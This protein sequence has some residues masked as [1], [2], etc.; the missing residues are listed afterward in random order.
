MKNFTL[1]I[2]IAATILLSITACSSD[3]DDNAN[4]NPEVYAAEPGDKIQHILEVDGTVV[5]HRFDTIIAR[6]D[7]DKEVLFSALHHYE[8]TS[9]GFS[10]L[11]F[12]LEIT[13]LDNFV[14]NQWT[15]DGRSQQR[16]LYIDFWNFADM[17]GIDVGQLISWFD[18]SNLSIVEF[19]KLLLAVNKNFDNYQSEKTE[20]DAF[21]SW[22]VMH[23]INLATFKEEIE[24]AGETFESFFRICND[25][26]ISMNAFLEIYV[27]NASGNLTVFINYILG[28]TKNQLQ[29]DLIDAANL[30][31]DI[32]K[33]GAPVAVGPNTTF[34]TYYPGTTWPDY[35]GG[36]EQTGKTLT[37]KTWYVPPKTGEMSEMTFYSKCTYDAK[38]DNH[39]GHWLQRYEIESDGWAA[40]FNAIAGKFSASEP[41]NKGTPSNIIPETSIS[42]HLKS[43]YFGVTMK[44]IILN[45]SVSGENGISKLTTP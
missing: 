40:P 34:H 43:W 3:D 25:N 15:L 9:E 37:Y 32:F 27:N 45:G 21:Y 22:V 33:A 16:N 26:S 44:S 12:D 1:C 36:K 19:K 14:Q 2:S 10:K 11:G 31:W 35:Y 24:S 4:P 18:E 6:G 30:V 13:A 5:V 20:L 7:T 8:V 41:I 23:N 38:N 39:A 28:L 42:I 29:S 17:L